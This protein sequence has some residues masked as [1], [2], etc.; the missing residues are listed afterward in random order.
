MKS[1][2]ELKAPEGK[3]RLVQ[4]DTFDGEEWIYGDF[5]TELEGRYACA[6]AGGNMLRAY[7]YNDRGQ[8][9]DWAGIY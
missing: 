8:C 9:I 4:V 6:K 2:L 1:N 7:L 3:F 5:D